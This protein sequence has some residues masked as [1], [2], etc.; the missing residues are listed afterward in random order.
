MK[1]ATIERIVKLTPIEGAD[2]I[3]VARVLGWN[4]VVKKDEFQ[5]GDLCV[6]HSPD[7][8]VDHTNPIY[9]FL[10]KT[11]FRLKT[12]KFKGIFSQGLA[13]PLSMIAH[14]GQAI[15]YGCDKEGNLVIPPSIILPDG[16]Q[17]MLTE[18]ADVTEVIK[19]TKYEKPIPACLAGEI[20]GGFPVHIVQRTDEPLLRSHPKVLPEFKDKYCMGTLK[21]DG[22][23]ATFIYHNNE[24]I[25]CSRNLRLKP[26]TGNSIWQIARKYDLE[27][28]MTIA[29][30]IVIQGEIVGPGIQKNKMGLK[31]LD[32]YAFNVLFPNPE[33]KYSNRATLLSTAE[34][35]GIKVVPLVW[36]GHIPDEDPIEYLQGITNLLTYPTGGPAE[37]MVIRPEFE[38]TSSVLENSRLSVKVINEHYK[39]E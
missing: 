25:V 3:L 30:S 15:P 29:N 38:E 7:T 20:A 5:E 9:D 12:T 24:F 11:N 26:S 1:L 37:G 31:E 36:S 32:F 13:L 14:Y 22:S 18:G 39:E 16:R 8:V 28:K 4:T 23:S 10:G 21:L 35:L 19:I 27:R 33:R 2:R 6:W 34:M 17:I